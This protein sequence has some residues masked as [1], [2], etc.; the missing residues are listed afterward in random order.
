MNNNEPRLPGLTDDEM[1]QL[2]DPL[3]SVQ[4]RM[5]TWQA[6]PLSVQARKVLQRRNSEALRHHYITGQTC[7]AITLL[8]WLLPQLLPSSSQVIDMQAL[9]LSLYMMSVPTM[10]VALFQAWAMTRAFTR[11]EEI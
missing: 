5:T 3:L 8:L 4:D 11:I 1:D 2:M 10:A 6:K 9:G 7:V